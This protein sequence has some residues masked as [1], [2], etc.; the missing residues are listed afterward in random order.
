MCCTFGDTTDVAWWH[1]YQLDLVEAIDREGRMT[2][3]ANEFSGLSTEVARKEIVE[4]SVE[5]G[6]VLS[7]TPTEQTVRVHER[8]DTPVEFVVARQWFIRVLEHKDQ[9]IEYGSRVRWFPDH[10]QIRF[11]QWVENLNWDW[12]ISRQRYYGVTFPVWY[13]DECGEPVLANRD[14]LPIDPAE[15]SPTVP[16]SCGSS[17]FSPERDVMD[18]WATS[19]LTPQF[20]GRWLGQSGF[21]GQAYKPISMRPQAHEIIR[22]WAFYSVVKSYHHFGEQPWKEVF[23]SGWGLAPEGSGKISKSR[24]GGPAPPMEMLERHSADAVRYWAASTGL[25]KDTAISDEKI[26]AGSK[27][28]TK[29][30]N[31]A[32]FSSRFFDDGAPPDEPANLS[33]ADRWLLSRTQRVNTY[34]SEKM[35]DYDYATAKSA[36]E[37]FF[38][39]ELADNYLE[40]AK[41][42]LYEGPHP[43]GDGARYSLYKVLLTILKL[44]APFLPY[45]TEE[46]YGRIYAGVHGYPSIHNS[47]WPLADEALI[48]EHYEEI[49]ETLVQIATAVRRYKSSAGLS[50]GAE[51][52]SLVIAGGDDGLRDDLQQAHSDLVSIT[53][54]VELR[55]QKELEPKCLEIATI[56][57]LHIGVV[58]LDE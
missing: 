22:T 23:I 34:V 53:R 25:G 13:C 41:Q 6:L 49:G 1:T 36:I 24:G 50:L 27:L 29:L 20:V 26:A 7:R 4:A 11:R 45:V 46:I 58:P 31:V 37:V 39:N 35:V 10:M 30:W 12:C 56:G 44:F 16:C 32:R 18:T 9:L 51:I 17:V 40:M 42:R 21:D 19:S 33:A 15:S 3:V 48:D 54:A 55:L 43:G 14:E 2:E 28:I 57:D 5:N 38:W 52:S 47:P 8:C